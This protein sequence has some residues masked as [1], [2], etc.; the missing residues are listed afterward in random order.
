MGLP[1]MDARMDTC[2]PIGRPNWCGIA[3]RYTLDECDTRVRSMSLNARHS[4]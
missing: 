4:F 2:C 1:S 3:K